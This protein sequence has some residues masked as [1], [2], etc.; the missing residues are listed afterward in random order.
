MVRFLKAVVV[1]FMAF[2]CPRRGWQ[3]VLRGSLVPRRHFPAANARPLRPL[4]VPKEVCG[5]IAWRRRRGRR[6]RAN[7]HGSRAS[8][9]VVCLLGA[10]QAVEP[11]DAA[12]PRARAGNPSNRPFLAEHAAVVVAHRRGLIRPMVSKSGPNVPPMTWFTDSMSLCASR[13][14]GIP[15]VMSQRSSET[16]SMALCAPAAGA[17][18]R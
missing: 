3:A 14:W 4:G 15:K 8:R 17:S 18:P 2:L 10:S 1:W 9:G 16:E 5:V 11:P 12:A 6:G 7:S 13:R